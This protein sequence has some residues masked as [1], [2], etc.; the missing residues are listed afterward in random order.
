[1]NGLVRSVVWLVAAAAIPAWAQGKPDV[2]TM[3]AFGG[4]DQVDSGN[5]AASNAGKLVEIVPIGD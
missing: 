2:L 5:N 3:K 1:M 4:T